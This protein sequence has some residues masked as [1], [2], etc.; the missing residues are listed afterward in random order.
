MT[1]QPEPRMTATHY[2]A[3]AGLALGMMFLLQ[4]QRA[5]QAIES[6]YIINVTML[7][8]GT[9]GILFRRGPSPLVTLIALAA[10][11]LLEQ[12]IRNRESDPDFQRTPILDLGNVLLSIATLTY[13]VSMYRLNLIQKKQVA[14]DGKQ[15]PPGRSE[16]SIQP[17]ELVALVFSVPVSALC[18]E[19]AF[20]LVKRHWWF[21]DMP[22]RWV[23]FLILAWMLLI[24][25]FL[26]RAFFRGWQRAVMSRLTA[27]VMM[28]D[29]AWNETRGEQRRIQRWMIWKRLRERKE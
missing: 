29:I 27:L 15:P 2:Q 22:P 20:F 26:A 8:I 12:F 9:V 23:Q 17:L 7:L 13:L 6:S 11:H 1:E 21:I 10:Q 25:L 14:N 3:V 16:Q 24:T 18:A 19:F 4:L 5:V 28:Q